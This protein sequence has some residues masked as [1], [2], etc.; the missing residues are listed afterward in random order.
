MGFFETARL[1]YDELNDTEKEMVSYIV[2]H[3]EDLLNLSINDLAKILKSSRS[4]ILRLSQK[5]GYRGYSQ[6]KYEMLTAMQTKE[7][8][9]INL[10]EQF[11]KDIQRTFELANQ[12]NFMPLLQAIDNA[13]QLIVYATGFVQN[14][15]AKQFSSELFMYGKPNF[16]VSGETNFNVIAN[17]LTEEDLV[18]IVSYSGNTPAIQNTVHLL[19]IK[20]VPICSITHLS[21][22]FLTD[23]SRYSLF[24]E[25]SEI[26]L[27]NG[28]GN[29]LNALG[30][31]MT[32]LARKYLEYILYDEI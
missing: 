19:N 5:L 32:I 11:H 17:T 16:L 3:L 12:V 28:T 27:P 26:P 9:P 20:K 29:S 13:Q 30:V 31:L 1:H 14:N 7:V 25:V 21:K 18:I 6:M 15:Y 10:E 4:S 2:D 8:I 24:Y 22:N 23:A